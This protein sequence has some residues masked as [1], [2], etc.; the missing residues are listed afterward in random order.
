MRQEIRKLGK[1]SH[2]AL[3]L[4]NQ[5]VECCVDY[6]HGFPTSGLSRDKIRG[7]GKVPVWN[8]CS[9]AMLSLP[10]RRI[11]RLHSH[12]LMFHGEHV[13]VVPIK[14]PFMIPSYCGCHADKTFHIPR[15]NTDNLHLQL[16][17][18]GCTHASVNTCCNTLWPKEGC[19]HAVRAGFLTGISGN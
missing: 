2:Q 1:M 13:F 9:A 10:Q 19:K 11:N 5:A 7:K 8:G 14:T 12:D 6:L 15:I 17:R 3:A 4:G 16:A 18:P